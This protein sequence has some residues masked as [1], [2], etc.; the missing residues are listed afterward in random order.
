MRTLTQGVH[1]QAQS[2]ATQHEA[3]QIEAS[4]RGLAMLAQE[5]D[6]NGEGDEPNG[7]VDVERPAPGEALDQEPTEDRTG[8]WT[9]NRGEHQD[10]PD[11]DA[12]LRREGAVEHGHADWGEQPTASPLQH[13]EG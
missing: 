3:R 11:G 12:L 2:G 9:E 8:S 5:E 6:P 7:D 13:P 10:A 4:R 1:D